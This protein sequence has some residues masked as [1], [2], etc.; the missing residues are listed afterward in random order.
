MTAYRN[1]SEWTM[2]GSESD[3]ARQ[4]YMLLPPYCAVCHWPADRPGRW[5]ELHHIVGG[6]GRK[7]LPNGENWISLCNR[8]HTAVHDK[9][10]E[11]GS[12]PRGAILTAKEE[13]D[14]FVDVPRLAAL[15]HRKAL[16]YDKCAIPD[17]F[18]ADRRRR[19]GKPWP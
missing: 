10:P 4:D 3:S 5:M 13:S 17:Q 12:L 14:G 18:L 8:C 16:P 1:G 6:A 15:K 2:G 7:D 9:H 11:Y 19:G